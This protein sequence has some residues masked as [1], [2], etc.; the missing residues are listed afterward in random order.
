VDEKL[1]LSF[2]SLEETHWW[3]V[4]R[5]R[6]VLDATARPA[7][8]PVRSILDVGCGTGGTM[9]ALRARFPDAEIKGVEPVEAAAR[10]AAGRGCDVTSGAFEHLPVE[11]ESVDIVMALDVLEHLADDGLGLA[12][13]FR[14]LRPG[15]R[16]VATVPALPR[17]WSVHD[18]LNGHF[19]RYT[20]AGL[21]GAVRAAGFRVERATYFNTLLLPLAFLERAALRRLKLPRSPAVSLP[22]RPLNAVLRGVFGLER[23]ILARADLPI[24]LSLLLVAS[25][26]GRSVV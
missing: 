1:L 12:E 11:G 3:F 8:R 6:I 18:E 5:R 7:P 4:V 25:R 10:I 15:G 23:P 24:G 26:T 21:V 13:A 16:L 14:A 22:P 17:Q 19:R 9:R 2:E 20:R